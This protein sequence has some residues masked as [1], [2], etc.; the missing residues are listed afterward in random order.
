MSSN[1]ITMTFTYVHA[2]QALLT[3]SSTN[4]QSISDHNSIFRREEWLLCLPVRYKYIPYS[5]TVKMS[6]NVNKLRK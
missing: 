1:R 5:L 2:D 6:L 4:L 3:K